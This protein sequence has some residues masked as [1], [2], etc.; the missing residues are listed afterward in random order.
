MLSLAKHMAMSGH[1][2]HEMPGYLLLLQ[3]LFTPPWLFSASVHPYQGTAPCCLGKSLSA[4]VGEILGVCMT[5]MG[6]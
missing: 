6:L 5:R 1:L 3:L 4:T 2:E